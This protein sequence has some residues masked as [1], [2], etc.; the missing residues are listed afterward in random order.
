MKLIYSLM[1]V[2][3]GLTLI[4]AQK[5]YTVEGIVHDFHDKTAL[6]NAEVKIGEFTART[7]HTGKF[8]F[9]KIPAGKYILIAR[10]PDCNDYTENIGV[11]RDVHLVITLEHHSN[12]I[13]TVTIH[14]SHKNNGSMVMKT[15]DKSVLSRNVTENLGNLLT[16]I[17]GV[18]V[19]KTGNNIAKPVIHGLY[20]SRVSILNDGVKLAEQEWGVE[21]APNVDVN[22]FEHIDV[23]KGA[24]ALK[25]GSGAV[26]GVV[27]LQPQVLP[28]KDTLMGSVSLSGIS[29]GRGADVNVKLAKTWESGWAV[30]TNGSFR[31]LG[32]LKA[33][34]YGLMNTG[35]QNSGFNFGVQKTTFN[36]GF[37]FDYYLTNNS[38]G[39]LR[40]S[41]VGSAEDLYEALSSQEPIFK[42]DFSYDIDNPRQ[43]I[44]HHIAKISGYHRFENFGKLT[45][46]YSFQYNHRK[47]YDIR[48]SEE[49]SK[50]PGLD[51]ELITNDLNINH[52]IERPKWSLETGINGGYQ[53]NYSNPE[54]EARR[55]VPNYDR[56]YAGVYSV[57]KYKLLPSLDLEAGA[58]Y[59]F[60]RYEVTKWYDLGDWNK[61]YAQDYSDF[62]VRINQNRI[63]T[64]PELNYNNFSGNAGISYHPSDNFN[65][66]LNYARVSRSPNVAELFAD[67]LHHSAAIIEEGD[68]RIKS[69]TGNQ[70]NLI[71]DAKLNVLGGLDISVNPYFFYTKN[72]INEVPTG[73]R[74]TQWGGDFVV[75]GYQQINVKMYGADVDLALKINDHL[76]Y[77]GNLSYVYGQDL[78]HD[79]P[80]IMMMPTN[81]NNSLEFSKKEW[82]NFYMNVSNKTVLAQTRFPVYNV[83]IKR[84]DTD[85]NAY[86][87]EVDISTPPK[88]YSLWN[89]QAGVNLSK[90]FGVDFSVKNIFNTSY[91]DYL[92]RLRYFSSEMGRNFIV[93]LKYQF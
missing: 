33:P 36:S 74:N 57:Y 38:I 91:R 81:F 7:D 37:S 24:S 35:I 71:A 18:N 9:N 20:G 64:K 5:T 11:D 77:K 14:G 2:L 60:D 51:L 56:F 42:R 30:K 22:N 46:T 93:T 16:N 55:L 70:F 31:K 54:T 43:E 1:L 82:K 34:G 47:E 15:L 6:E 25:Y 58:R 13:E 21:H 80:L 92:N 69:E 83:F 40:S 68:M 89:L 62:A 84:Y 52:L 44:E 66:K 53:N 88:T 39:I 29:N 4:S 48:R 3:C 59:D 23:I 27:V 63:L 10:H 67:G 90:N 45:A 78:T 73:Y 85:G 17:S 87:Q 32:D 12:D 86:S 28:K 8:T 75:Y 19:L 76:A 49:L 26:G 61:L 65:L 72:F 79:V 41:H 50:K